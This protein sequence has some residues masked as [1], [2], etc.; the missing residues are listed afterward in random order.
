MESEKQLKA[1]LKY[2]LLQE[3]QMLIIIN[4]AQ[5]K[6]YV[7]Q[8]LYLAQQIKAEEASDKQLIVIIRL[9]RCD[10]AGHKDPPVQISHLHQY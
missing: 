9:H 10:V 5:D 3:S 8:V 7:E 2:G 4:Y 1:E 6:Q